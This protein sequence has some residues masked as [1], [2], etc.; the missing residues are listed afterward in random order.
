[1]KKIFKSL[2][3]LAIGLS[4][5]TGCTEAKTIKSYYI[6]SNN[7]L[8]VVYD[9]NSETNL[10]SWGE[11]IIDS[12]TSIT[13][14]SD[15]YYIING[16]KTNIKENTPITYYLDSSGNLIAKYADDTTENLGQFSKSIIE[17]LGTVSISTDGYYVI[18][19]IKTSIK[20]KVPNS[21]SVDSNGHLIVTYTD[22]TYEDLGDLSESLVNG[23]E[24][25][26]ISEDGFYVINGVKTSILA[27]EIYTVSF[28]TGFS[29]TIEPQKV[30]D[31]YK[32]TRPEIDRTGYTLNGWYC[33]DEEWRFNSDV[34]KSDMTLTAEWTANKYTISFNNEKGAN[35]EDMIVTYDSN[36]ILPSVSPVAGYTFEG[37]YNGATKVNDGQWTIA[38][39]ITL[40]ARWI[41]NEYTITLD[42][43]VGSVSKTSVSVK[44]NEP[45]TLPIPTNSYGVFTGW[46][47]DGEKVTDNDGKS[48]TNWTYTENKTF[49]V[50]WTIKVTN[51]DELLLMNEFKNGE[52]I[53]MNDI[54]LTNQWTPVGTKTDPFTGI[55]HGNNKTISDLTIVADSTL[56]AYGL[57]GY[58]SDATIDH[59][60]L[61]DVSF[62]AGNLNKSY[63]VGALIGK[64]STS[65]NP[66]TI[67]NV[68]VS[69]TYSIT[70]QSSSFPIIAGGI[71][72][73]SN[74]D[75][76][77]CCTNHISIEN[78]I[79][80]GGIMGSAYHAT[81][82]YCYNDAEISASSYAGG[83]IGFS[84]E[85]AHCVA[86]KNDGKVT[87]TSSAGGVAGWVSDDA[88]FSQCINNGEIT[89]STDSYLEGA[90]GMIGACYGISGYS[91]PSV[92][93]TNS[94]NTGKI[95][96]PCAGGLVGATYSIGIEKAY[97]K[98]SISA[99]KY[100]G[101]LYG[102]S[103]KYIVKE[104]LA[105]G[106]VSSSIVKSI[107][108]GGI[109]SGSCPDSYYTFSSSSSWFKMEG[110][111][112]N[113]YYGSYLYVNDMFW[114]EY[115][116]LTKD[117]IWIFNDS[118]YPTLAIE[119][120][121]V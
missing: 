59:L 41:T 90:G 8:I 108:G 92:D 101:A 52:F 112:T 39:D 88:S 44:Y 33:N 85:Y 21:Y 115:D 83:I 53:L 38:S 118:N 98:G 119:F 121:I 6:D 31:G 70:K 114:S 86:C 78:V 7:N 30:K 102:I 81:P 77:S 45:Y 25:I 28:N 80:G 113:N 64:G 11:T 71:I 18:N 69:G 47:L 34:V 22:G 110:T 48:L 94:Y 117:G 55:L 72:G 116:P 97:N 35:P 23:I 19:G 107:F 73:V 60:K 89:S 13:V 43:G 3:I 84:T 49:T 105:S 56:D 104:S 27:I 5:L 1:M 62:T 67:K 20:A 15:G 10:G 103:Q 75:S 66:T 42:P 46:L 24:T 16:V 12:F 106:S 54:V 63:S 26:E 91:T 111:Y 40:T 68:E 120:G 4:L 82:Q 58:S 76:I 32:V 109:T 95:T 29:K 2:S 96:A 51:E 93:V 79:Y 65:Q 57:I 17:S 99:S 50:D 87:A 9:D 37:W 61:S 74:Q 100:A 36:V 14:S